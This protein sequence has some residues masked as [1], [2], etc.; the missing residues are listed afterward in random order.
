MSVAF[1]PAPRRPEL[2]RLAR[3]LASPRVRDGALLERDESMRAQVCV[4][5]SGAGGATVASELVRRGHSVV[6]LEEGAWR[7]G[8]DFTGDADEMAEMLLPGGAATRTA[9]ELALSIPTGRCVGGTTV[10]GYGTSQRVPDAVLEAWEREHGVSGLGARDLEA[11]F[12]RAEQELGVAPVPEAFVGRNASLLAR[13]AEVLG[14]EGGRVARSVSGCL[15]T[16]VCDRGCPQDA[17]LGMHVLTVPRAVDAGAIVYTHAR[18]DKLLLSGARAFGVQASLLRADGVPT[19]RTLRVVCDRVVVACGALASPALLL[20]SGI[21]PRSGQLGRNLHLQPAVRVL[22]SFPDEVRAFE[23]VPQAYEV[24]RTLA[25][26]IVVHGLPA[27]LATLARALPQVGRTKKAILARYARLAALAARVAD[28]GNGSVELRR[29]GTPVV[30]Y[31]LTDADRRRLLHGASLAAELLFAAGADEVYPALRHTQVLR[32]AAEAEALREADVAELD[33]AVVAH[34]PLGTARM[35]DDKQ[36]GVT[37]AYG[38]VHDVQ[39]LYVVD[40]SLLPTATTVAPQTT[41]VA[42]ALRI[43]EHISD[44]VGAPLA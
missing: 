42:L 28:D 39:D 6:L 33:V 32:S 24:G 34:H 4:V 15:A 10:M 25:D 16:G 26:G 31:R 14:H 11:Y 1:A 43:A 30:K 40:A 44:S 22:A 36:Q 27:P 37:N 41:I 20:R 9:D 7:T 38:A 2:E 13:G 35:A 19:G 3:V 18:A 21:V 23:E 29:D 17:Q 8:R 12:A 5:G